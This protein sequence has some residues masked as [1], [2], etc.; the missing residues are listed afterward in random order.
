MAHL[1][2]CG[3][4]EDWW[5]RRLGDVHWQL[6]ADAVGQH[7]TVFRNAEGRQIY[8]AF[9]TTEFE[10]VDPG[11]AKLGQSIELRSELWAGGTSRLQSNHVLLCDDVEI[12]RFRFVSAF[13][14][15]LEKGVNASV[16]R[17]TPYLLPV[18]PAAPDGFA[19]QASALARSQR[20]IGSIES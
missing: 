11:R 20:S 2:Y 7:T 1:S 4:S 13:V 16:S 17:A 15:H 10:Q 14:T 19:Q 6:I 8:A 18:I 5:L 12:A 3:L 9:C